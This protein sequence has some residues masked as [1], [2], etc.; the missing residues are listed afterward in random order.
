[1]KKLLPVA[2]IV[3]LVFIGA[4]SSQSDYQV[5]PTP[6]IPEEGR[7]VP[8]AQ[9]EGYMRI[10]GDLR[11]DEMR[12]S[13]RW[14]DRFKSC[15]K[16]T[17]GQYLSITGERVSAYTG[18]DL[19]KECYISIAGVDSV[20]Q[21]VGFEPDPKDPS[22][23]RVSHVS[24]RIVNPADA[25]GFFAAVREK[26]GEGDSADLHGEDSSCGSYACIGGSGS[27]VY[28]TPT[29]RVVSIMDA[30]KIKKDDI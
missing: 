19:K 7:V 24:F 6:N 3:I 18:G 26:Y 21:E 28:I 12:S 22:K 13:T 27:F 5:N 15:L 9:Q 8:E 14:K 20:L 30:V 23:T 2:S 29:D 1:M 16:E 25:R 10:I 17:S 11:W 4:C